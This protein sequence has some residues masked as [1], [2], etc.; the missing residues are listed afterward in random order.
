MLAEDHKTEATAAA[1]TATA[2]VAVR[3]SLCCM[4]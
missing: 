3:R 4:G 2:D 1:A